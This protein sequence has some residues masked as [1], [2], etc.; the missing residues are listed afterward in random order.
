MSINTIDLDVQIQNILESTFLRTL[1]EHLNNDFASVKSIMDDIH[2]FYIDSAN[3][4]PTHAQ[5]TIYKSA[6]L[7][8]ISEIW[9]KPNPE[10]FREVYD[11]FVVQL[12]ELFETLPVQVTVEQSADRFKIL[13]EDV[14]WTRLMK[15][16]KKSAFK[17][18]KLPLNFGNLFRKKKRSISFWRHRVPLRNLAR[19]H[20]LA[21]LINDLNGLIEL[22]LP[23]LAQKYI[24]LKS[25]EERLANGENRIEITTKEIAIFE[26]SIIEEIT[27]QCKSTVQTNH[28]AFKDA[29][30]KV[31]TFELPGGKLSDSK[32][33]KALD[34]ACA[35]WSDQYLTWKNTVFAVFEEWRLDLSI[36]LLKHS[37]HAR[38]LEFRKAQTKKVNEFVRPEFD[39]VKEFI[40]NGI[41]AITK[42]DDSIQKELKVLN[43]Q[44]IKKL[45]KDLVPKLCEKISN[46]SVINLINHLEVS[47]EQQVDGLSDER[48]VVKTDT[49]DRP[50]Q[51]A[52]LNHISPRELITF[53]MLPGLKSKIEKIKQNSFTGLQ[54]TADNIKD[55]DHIITF[56]LSS[57]ISSLNA[58]GNE[59]QAQSIAL[60]GLKRAQLR[61]QEE[62]EK[63]DESIET[64]ADQL[65]IAINEF[66]QEILELTFNENVRELRMRLTKAK[67]TQQ[68]Q[69]VRQKFIERILRFRHNI[70]LTFIR[71]YNDVRHT[72]SRISEKFILTAKK[73][74]ITKQVSDFLLESQQ[75]IDRLPLI[76]KRLYQIEPLEDL[77]LFEG[78]EDE[79]FTLKKAFESWQKGHYAASIIIG[80]KWGGLSSFLTYA[81]ARAQ[82][83]YKVTRLVVNDNG[84]SREHLVSV[85]K[86]L[87]EN[88][89]FEEVT[90]IITYLNEVPHRIIVLE[91]I[92]NLFL[93]KIYGFE[94]LQCLFQLINQTYKN[95]FWIASTTAYSWTYLTKTVNINEYFS[96]AITLKS[97]TDEQINNLIWK[98]NR[99]SGFKILFEADAMQVNQRSFKKLNYEQQQ[100]ELKK[101]YFSDLNA[102][103]KSN[104]SLALIYWLLS[105]REIDDTSITIGTF[106]KPNLNFISML[107]AD[108]LYALHA[109]ILHDGL[110]LEQLSIVMQK[111]K[112][113]TEL[114]ILALLEDG[115]V[116]R[117]ADV[118]MINPIVYRNTVSLLHSKNLIH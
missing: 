101:K 22:Y 16:F 36:L 69:E 25:W 47:I 41:Q 18:S 38:M 65:E 35:K 84:Y 49:Y 62:R 105:T 63:L 10:D 76:Y 39:A 44:A 17:I 23:A 73:P 87:L 26:Q 85:F 12:N 11:S 88:D 43:Y 60:E 98:R 106:K 30:E 9:T 115:V 70:A 28:E 77:E 91:D 6:L 90:D 72:W 102:F 104:I 61:L 5:L 7:N 53:E 94:A 99:I 3:S 19:K 95:I 20:F 8:K 96:Y 27:K 42:P 80:E 114:I 59:Q 116:I 15:N 24:N 78:R 54:T 21:D 117:K 64:N 74:E 79:F 55:L 113:A 103:A 83:P 4:K 1:N 58:D 100:I 118:F 75:K 31:G 111:S 52:E 46:Q 51:S 97:L 82:F 45:D 29:Y 89:E 109:L 71:L 110:N 66:S 40:E 81:L 14:Q 33:E 108:K 92:Q 68:A 37:I 32:I 112:M 86:K 34:E 48:V 67:T 50:V 107:S 13:P 56:S 2:R 93:R 57:S